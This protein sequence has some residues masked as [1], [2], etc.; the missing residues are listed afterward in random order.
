MLGKQR[1]TFL[2]A[3]KAIFHFLRTHLYLLFA[4]PLA[5]LLLGIIGWGMLLENLEQ[6][7]KAA[8]TVALQQA[9]VLSRSYAAHLARV[10]ESIDQILLHLRFEWNLSKGNLLLGQ[11]NKEKLFLSS[12]FVFASI[13]DANGVVVSSTTATRV[14]LSIRDRASFT[15]QKAMPEDVL[16]IAEPVWGRASKQYVVAFSRKLFDSKRK[17]NGLVQVGVVPSYLTENYDEATSGKHGFLGVAG[18]DNAL[19][20]TR[21]GDKVFVGE[22]HALVAKPKLATPSGRALFNGDEWFIDK[23]SRFV[24]WHPV[25]AYPLIGFAGLDKSEALSAYEARRADSFRSAILATITLGIFT[26]IAMTLSLRLAWRRHQLET[27]KATYRMATEE[28]NEGF[29]IARPVYERSGLAADFEFI[30]CNHHGAEFFRLRREG[31]IGLRVSSLYD[32]TSL[33]RLMRR[34]RKAMDT[35]FYEGELKVS[36]DSVGPARWLQ[37]KMVRSGGDLAIT[38]CDISNAKAH[39]VEL[40]RRSNQDHLTSLPNR[41]WIQTYLPKAIEQAAKRDEMVALLFVDLDGFKSVNDTLGHP[42]GDEL[43]RY[44]ATRLTAAVRPQDHVVRLGG[45]EFVTILEHLTAKDEAVP[46]AER[47]LRAFEENFHLVNGI[48]SLQV[49]VGISVFPD[50]G[51]DADTLLQNA[52]LAMYSVK[53]SGKGHYRFF[54][55]HFRDALQARFEKELEIRKAIERDQF[56]LHYQPRVDMS[57]GI[58]RSMEALVRWAHPQK[59]LLEPSEFIWLAEETG[60][61]LE[62]G[63]LII[64]KVCAQL[65]DWRQAGQHLLPVS[66]N[67]SPRQIHETN[68]SK[69]FSAAIARHKIDPGLLEIEITESS[70][71]GESEDIFKLLADLHEMGI[72]LSIDDF[73]TGYSSLSQL[74]QFDFDILK[75]DRAFILAID[76]TDEGR[77][78]VNAIITM[79]HAL[80]MCVVAEGV[81]NHRQVMILQALRCDEI[82]GYYVSRPLPPSQLN[83]ILQKQ[84]FASR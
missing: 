37:V 33:K 63:E 53:T 80:R 8:E 36:L 61:I 83:S 64:D 6:N 57:T 13:I 39:V 23:R 22:T 30:D 58:T 50:D 84:F 71:I 69:I 4:W 78:F 26:C 52:D 75:I 38:A 10:F 35:G 51:T 24:A 17:F 5:A 55:R 34:L 3:R 59:G 47:I 27:V 77:I 20:A 2:A 31:L 42:A 48:R 45:D 68:I 54:E 73:G 82:Q 67:V 28:G 21:L 1:G 60:L 49:S 12:P 46:A 41:Y 81:E 18:T 40:Q 43:L 25:P 32:G 62:L 9:E 29:Y 66:I 79:A 15:V 72:K 76:K 44:A 74:Q 56:V 11:M 70:M 19:R 16:H 14:G 7:R 65:A